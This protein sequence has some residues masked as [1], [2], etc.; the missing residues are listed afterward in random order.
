MVSNYFIEGT[1]TQQDFILNSID[2]DPI[3]ADEF[4][5]D[6]TGPA[7]PLRLYSSCYIMKRNV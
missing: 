2:E 6:I 7:V 4:E 3:F 1:L 5:I